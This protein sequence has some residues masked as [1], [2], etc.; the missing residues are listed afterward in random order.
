MFELKKNSI[1][2][3]LALARLR[4]SGLPLSWHWPGTTSRLWRKMS[5]R[6]LDVVVLLPT[7]VVAWKAPFVPGLSQKPTCSLLHSWIILI[8]SLLHLIFITQRVST[9]IRTWIWD[10]LK[11]NCSFLRAFGAKQSSWFCK[12]VFIL[13]GLFLYSKP[14]LSYSACQILVRSA[15]GAGKI[16][17]FVS[18][19]A[20]F[21]AFILANLNPMMFREFSKHVV[22]LFL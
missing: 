20:V 15:Q 8:H 14:V 17:S 13:K 12:A 4:I 5:A 10:F 18:F 19:L 22:S 3:V 21:C 1:F 7:L 9:K 11:L 6:L 16:I 2:L